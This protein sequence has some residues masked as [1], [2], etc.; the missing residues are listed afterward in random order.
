M[1]EALDRFF[2]VSERGSNLATE[3]VAGLTTFLSLSYIVVVNPAILGSGGF[4]SST[5]F[6]ATVLASGVGTIVLGIYARLPFAIAPGMEMNAYVALYMSGVLGLSAPQILGAVLISG[7]IFFVFSILRIRSRLIEA[8][9][10]EFK[11][12]LAASVGAFILAVALRIADVVRYDGNKASSIGNI[13]SDGA[14]VLLVG[15]LAAIILQRFASALSILGSVGVS[16]LAAHWLGIE[17]ALESPLFSITTGAVWSKLALPDPSVLMAPRALGPVL[18]LLVIDFY[19]SV[20]KLVGLS[21]YTSI[22]ENGRVPRMKEALLVDSGST[23][24]GAFL[25]TSNLTVFVESAAGIAAGGRTGLTAVTCGVLILSTML[26]YPILQLVPVAA[27]AG[28]LA[29]VAYSLFPWESLKKRSASD[30]FLTATMAAVTLYTFSLDRALFWGFTLLVA[31]SIVK[32]E[33]VSLFVLLSASLLGL[34]IIL[35]R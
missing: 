22:Q 23:I 9:P 17:T 14:I 24:A 7:L 27:S 30:Q 3:L 25:G 2:Q 33:R 6:V 5:V 31:I 15:V 8:V 11:T 1:F 21:M 10:D 16:A 35:Q 18:V 32:R 19:G 20:S 34:A 4:D 26:A 13:G 29:Y 12:A 28:A